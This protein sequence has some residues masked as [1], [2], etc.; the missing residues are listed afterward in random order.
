MEEVRERV[1]CPKALKPIAI[2]YSWKKEASFASLYLWYGDAF[3]FQLYKMVEKC[4][5]EMPSFAPS[6][7]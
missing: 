4:E 6:H 3:F 1:F 2:L 7:R 5:G